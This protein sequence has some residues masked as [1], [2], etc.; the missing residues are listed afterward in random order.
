MKIIKLI[1]VLLSVNFASGQYIKENISKVYYSESDT[2]KYRYSNY[3]DI[4]K[5][6]LSKNDTISPGTN[7]SKGIIMTAFIGK[8]TL[9]IKG[10]NY[11]YARKSYVTIKTPKRT[12]VVAFRFNA[13][14][15]NF[16]QEYINENQGKNINEGLLYWKESFGA[17]AISQDFYEVEIKNHTLLDNVLL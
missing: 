8:D 7:T 13:S 14:S 5:L 9:S 6:D 1:I 16:S 15:S 11:P 3:P 4:F 10:N 17:R 12:T 2:I